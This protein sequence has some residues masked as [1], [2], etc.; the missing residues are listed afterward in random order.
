[1][2]DVVDI[3]PVPTKDDFEFVV[4]LARFSEG[5]VSEADIKRKY[6]LADEAWEKYGTDDELVRAI[7]A[8]KLRRV[9]NGDNKREKS[10]LLITKAPGIL[11]GIMSDPSASPRHRVDA[12]KTLDGFAANGPAGAPASDRFQIVINLGADTLKFDRSILPDPNDR[13]P[14]HPDDR[15]FPAIT[16]KKDDDSG[17]PV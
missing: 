2:G 12:I 3:K 16:A 4:D 7:E 15:V 13:D 6:R 9:R 8:E 17:E 5:I 11:D 1:M 10:Q 14:H